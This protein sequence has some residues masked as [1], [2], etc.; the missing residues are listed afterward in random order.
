MR[1]T[2]MVL[3]AAFLA[4][5]SASSFAQTEQAPAAVEQTDAAP[6][7]QAAP[8][9]QTNTAAPQE[10]EL[11]C[12]TVRRTESRLRARTERTCMTQTQ[13]DALAD[14]T[15]RDVRGMGQVQSAQD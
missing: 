6:A 4:A 14:Q 9:E 7:E 3:A 13:W 15:A 5:T 1:I 11:V 10:E 2:S 8:V 12:R